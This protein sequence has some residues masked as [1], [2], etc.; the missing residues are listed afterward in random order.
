MNIIEY[1][2][3]GNEVEFSHSTICTQEKISISELNITTTI[4]C[5]WKYGR[6][7]DKHTIMIHCT[8]LVVLITLRSAH[9]YQ[10]PFCRPPG[11]CMPPHVLWLCVN[12]MFRAETLYPI[13]Y[14]KTTIDGT[15]KVSLH[16]HCAC[17]PTAVKGGMEYT[18]C[19]YK[20]ARSSFMDIWNAI[21]SRVEHALRKHATYKQ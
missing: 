18:K 19:C 2:E 17:L 5:T 14:Q 1:A 12:I 15:V 9:H 6:F 7:S 13:L 20:R 21:H 11:I 16:H 4:I 3:T 10:P 8:C